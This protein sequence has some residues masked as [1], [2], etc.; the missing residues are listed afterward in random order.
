MTVQ[1]LKVRW[2]QCRHSTIHYKDRTRTL[3]AVT[4]VEQ[5]SHQVEVKTPLTPHPTPTGRMKHL[6]SCVSNSPR[7]EPSLSLSRIKPGD[8]SSSTWSNLSSVAGRFSR[9][10]G[11][12]PQ[13]GHGNTILALT[14]Q[15]MWLGVAWRGLAWRDVAWRDVTWRGVA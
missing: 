8:G 9:S 10:S 6:S 15:Q 14:C 7:T 5:D 1:P 4:A 13:K 3:L 2:V 12:F 11:A